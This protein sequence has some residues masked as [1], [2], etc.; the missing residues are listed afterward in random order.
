MAKQ[1]RK[2]KTE[3]TTLKVKMVGHSAGL[4]M[5]KYE[6]ENAAGM[7][8]LAAITGEATIEPGDRTLVPTGIAIE[9]PKGFEAQVRPRSGLALKKGVT[10]LNAPG[11]VDADY[12]GE[13][14]VILVNHGEEAFEV[15]RGMRIAQLVIAPV[16]KAEVEAAEDLSETSRGSGGFGST[17]TEGA[18][19]AE[20]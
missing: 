19:D 6:T 16:T 5:P 11:T 4:A 20:E 2:K 10:V 13:V 18:G 15:R 17:D 7:D 9:L 3:R 8:L 14:G 12:R 1:P